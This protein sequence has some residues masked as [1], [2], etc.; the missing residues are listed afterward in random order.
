MNKI[1]GYYRDFFETNLTQF[2]RNAPS[3]KGGLIRRITGHLLY[4][5]NI[6]LERNLR[7]QHVRFSKHAAAT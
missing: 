6:F 5:W 3:N 4:K 2:P 1:K 7:I